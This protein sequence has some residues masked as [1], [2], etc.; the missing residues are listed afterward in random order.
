MKKRL[1]SLLLAVILLLAL[2]TGAA[3]ATEM[4]FSEE[5]MTYIK[6]GEGFCPRAYSDGTGWYIG[7]GCACDPADWPD[8][9]TEAEADALLREKAERFA[10]AI[11]RFLDRYGV[12]VTQGQFDALCA[13]SYNFGDGW[14]DPSNRLPSYLINGVENYTEQQIASAFGA[15]CHVGGAAS[16]LL[17]R[18]RIMEAKMFLYED[19]GFTYDG[20]SWL[21]LDA[22][23]GKNELSDV[24][25]YKTGEA[26]GV[27][28]NAVRSGWYFAGWQ[29]TSGKTLTVADTVRG[30]LSVT[31]VW[32]E[33]PLNDR[34]ETVAAAASGVFPDVPADEWYA[35]YVETL[36]AQGVVKGY[37][38]GAFRPS[39]TV[40]WGEALKLVLLSA[41]L[42]EQTAE[43]DEHWAAGYLDY[44]V[45]NGYIATDDIM[46]DSSITR[47]E[48]ADLC[49]A[50]LE[51]GGTDAAGGQNPFADT[52]RT[53]VLALYGA[54]IVEGSV[55]NGQRLYKGADRIKRSE[56]CA[57]LA[58]MVSYVGENFVFVSGL[59]AAINFDL[60]MN[61]YDQTAFRTANNGRVYYDGPA[62]AV[63]YGIDV[64]K[65]QGTIDW[66]KVAADG[67]DFAM[68]R[69]GY[70][71]SGAGT[72]NEDECFRANIAGAT[73]A[74]L[75]VGV[76]FFSQALTAA[77]AVEEAKYTLELIEGHNLTYPVVFDWEPQ[78][79]SGS[80]TNRPNWTAVTDAAV[81][82]CDAVAAA[83]Y[84][85]MVYFNVTQAYLRLDMARLQKYDAWL[86][87]YHEIPDYIYDYQIWQYGSTGS[88]AG[89][90]GNVDMDICFKHY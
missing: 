44:A 63:R 20:W 5:L 33:T 52:S 40:T 81:A 64:S 59:R 10:A 70:R 6:A 16:E 83:G 7:Y 60:P 67:V 47:G 87:W 69:C 13:M 89:I 57:V 34:G 37:E 12:T 78:Y 77:E 53:S 85:P 15:W 36:A 18:R 65:W 24:A 21:L 75:D 19:Y 88:V 61:A 50:A 46:L 86:A 72:L 84:T 58:R 31:A 48:I 23:G 82:F 8:G 71:G 79:T 38:D 55:E 3:A 90:A 49:A 42:P 43:Q 30:N 80:R 25:L 17:L 74:G 39:N 28:P 29:T 22:N 68:I 45:R 51:L 66:K 54:G 62:E 14:L 9:I 41:G 56:I 35:G 32:S 1:C 76:Y 11:N 27:L 2:C 4:S 26:Y 73:A